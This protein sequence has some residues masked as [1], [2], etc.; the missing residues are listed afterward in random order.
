MY[1]WYHLSITVNILFAQEA[2]HCIRGRKKGMKG[3]LSIKVDMSKA[4]N[5]VECDFMR[6]MLRRLGFHYIYLGE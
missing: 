2:C 4:H 6:E 5:R 1:Y 3:F